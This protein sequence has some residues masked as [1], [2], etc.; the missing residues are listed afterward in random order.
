MAGGERAILDQLTGGF[1]MRDTS[2][3]P[4]RSALSTIRKAL[5]A[6]AALFLPDAIQV[7]MSAQEQVIAG[8]G[9]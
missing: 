5:A 6:T 4:G 7:L 3:I 8:D 1:G 2:R 9:G